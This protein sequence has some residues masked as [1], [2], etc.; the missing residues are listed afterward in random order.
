MIEK[1]YARD[2]HAPSYEGADH[3][4][5]YQENETGRIVDPEAE[6]YQAAMVREEHGAARDSRLKREE[7][8]PR[9]KDGPKGSGKN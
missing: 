2:P 4:L 3:M 7:D 8:E 9:R 5:G 1:A 6:K